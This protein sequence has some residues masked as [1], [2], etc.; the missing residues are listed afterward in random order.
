MTNILY[1]IGLVSRYKEEPR[2]THWKTIKQILHYIRGTLSLGLFYNLSANKFEIL[3][4]RIVIGVETRIIERA[5]P[6]LH[7]TWVIRLSHVS[8][9]VVPKNIR[10]RHGTSC[11]ACRALIVSCFIRV[12]FGTDKALIE[13]FLSRHWYS[14]MIL[15]TNLKID[16]AS[17]R[18]FSS[19][20]AS[21]L[22]FKN[23]VP[24]LIS[25]VIQ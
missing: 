13:I 7:F 15:N 21:N 14:S 22:L 16:S 5:H 8:C 20:K 9:R 11:L 12:V 19:R 24:K 17:Y 1:A 18:Y 4:I 6:N 25:S 10:R 2:T 23:Y 3:A